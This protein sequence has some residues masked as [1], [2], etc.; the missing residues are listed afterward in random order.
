MNSV[1]WTLFM[2][3]YLFAMA[4]IAAGVTYWTAVWAGL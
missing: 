1:R 4:Y 2:F 3:G